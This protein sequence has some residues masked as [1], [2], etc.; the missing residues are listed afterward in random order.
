MSSPSPALPGFRLSLGL[1]LLFLSLIVLLPMAALVLQAS[2]GSSGEIWRAVTHPRI[3]ASY[4]VTV[5]T[6][7]IAALFNGLF[8][9][10]MAWIL[11][12]YRFPGRRLLDALMD[13][14]FALPTAVAGLTLSALFATN[15]W[16]GSLL[17]PLGIR[18]SYTEAGIVL[19]MA[20]TSLP[21]VVR[22]IQPVLEDM[23]P[24]YE[25]ASASLG[26]AP[27][28]TFLRV[29][30]PILFPA[31]VVGTSLSFVR[32]LGEYGA[33]IFIAGNRP[34]ETEV[35]SLMVFTRISEYEYHAAASVA[36]LVA[37]TS[38]SIL[39]LV[40]LALTPLIRRLRD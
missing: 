39:S 22:T 10:L 1:G 36:L 30:L 8:G 16:V 11:V 37:V 13:L 3:L 31:L 32:N 23:G 24:E 28:Q 34:F 40:H 29:V 17:L 9:L 26:A 18:I 15:G 27:W 19:A 6:A 20:F 12:R 7:L 4:Q 2:H 38:L 33:V 5:I 21:F 14:P 25:E 35:V